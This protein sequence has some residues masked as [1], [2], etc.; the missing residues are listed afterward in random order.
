VAYAEGEDERVL[1]A[2]QVV[3][4]RRPGPAHPDRPPRRDRARIAKA[5]LRCKLGKDFEVVN[6]EDDP[7]FRQYWETYHRLMG[8]MG[9]TPDV[10]KAAVRRSN[11]I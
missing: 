7:R 4:R 9:V 1:R 3:H 6:P 5:G 10:A 2:V 11:T 8:A